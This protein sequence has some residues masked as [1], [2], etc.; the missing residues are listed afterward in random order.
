[1]P[2]TERLAEQDDVMRR[3]EARNRQATLQRRIILQALMDRR[4]CLT[5]RE[6]YALLQ[7][8]HSNIGQATVYRTL[9]LLVEAGAA[10]RFVQENNES[11]Y[12]Y[13][14]PRHHH[15][16]I[17]TRCGLVEDI[18]GCVIPALGATLE[19]R[20]RFQINEHAVTFYGFC[21]DCK[22]P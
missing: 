17:C 22:S 21:G 13:C 8:E 12:I 15:H 10:T 6:L 14:P 18:D 2:T 16:L 9:E 20:T 11:K 7:R 4:S 5:P 19:K 3:L 1:M